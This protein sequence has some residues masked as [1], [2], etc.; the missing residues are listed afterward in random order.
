MSTNFVHG[1]A[2]EEAAAQYLRKLKFEILDQNWR[3]RYC[4]I[5]IVALKSKTVYL[6]EVKYRRTTGQGTGLDYI[7]ASKLKQMKLA[8]EL[9]VA[10]NNWEG[11]YELAAVE[12]SGSSYLVTA[13]VDRIS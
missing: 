7:T 4:E 11:D 1:R 13:F 2:A 6:I 10:D 8:G 12:V 3:T 5:D 9:W